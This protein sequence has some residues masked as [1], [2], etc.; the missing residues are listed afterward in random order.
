MKKIILLLILYFIFLYI[1]TWRNLLVIKDINYPIKN[2]YLDN[3]KTG[4]IFLLGN[5]KHRKIFGDSIF[6]VNFIH[7]S[8]S[9]WEDSKLYII[10]FAI[11]PD[12]EGLIKIPFERWI[13]YNKNKRILQNCLE[14]KDE[15][16]EDRLKLSDKILQYYEEKKERINSMNRNFDLSW[17]RFPLRI[18]RDLDIN[19]ISCTE[20]LADLLYNCGIAKKDKG[21]SYYHQEDFISLSGFE[22]YNKFS[23]PILLILVK[24]IYIMYIH[25]LIRGTLIVSYQHL[26]LI[27]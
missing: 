8:I 12:Q 27:H 15:K 26:Y 7:P 3:I 21:V 25:I 14:I 1:Y 5:K 9:V 16:K 4:D 20:V 17:L 19:N 18:K 6:M 2:L 24:Y 11:Y 22:L 23:Y 10:E 13:R